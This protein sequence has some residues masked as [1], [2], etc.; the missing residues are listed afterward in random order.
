MMPNVYMNFHLK[1]IY[2]WNS[3]FNKNEI[4]GKPLTVAY[5]ERLHHMHYMTYRTNTA[6]EE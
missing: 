2:E 4:R 5:M 6:H 3:S 1:M